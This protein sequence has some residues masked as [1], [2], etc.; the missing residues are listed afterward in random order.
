MIKSVLAY[1][2]EDNAEGYFDNEKLALMKKEAQN[3]DDIIGEELIYYRYKNNRAV[4]LVKILSFKNAILHGI[5][6]DMPKKTIYFDIEFDAKENI[7]SPNKTRLTIGIT[8]QNINF[9]VEDYYLDKLPVKIVDG[10]FRIDGST[11]FSFD[12]M[13]ANGE[14]HN[15][16]INGMDVVV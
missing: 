14:R 5:N 11:A 9:N 7:L 10:D 1:K 2:Y 6:I 8:C 4:R 3:H 15:I 13:T 16:T 12:Y